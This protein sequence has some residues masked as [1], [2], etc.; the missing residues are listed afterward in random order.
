MRQVGSG[1]SRGL[2]VLAASKTL[3]PAQDAFPLTEFEKH[4]KLMARLLLSGQWLSENRGNHP[5][6]RAFVPDWTYP[7]WDA[8]RLHLGQPPRDI[9]EDLA[10]KTRAKAQGSRAKPDHTAT[11]EGAIRARSPFST[12][13]CHLISKVDVALLDCSI[14]LRSM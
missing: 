4:R 6:S 13:G 10:Q 11:T 9:P 3:P 2:G 12:G 1:G 5:R 14:L 7:K 8:D